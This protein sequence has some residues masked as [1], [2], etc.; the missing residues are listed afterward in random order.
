[1]RRSAWPLLVLAGL[2][3]TLS[4]ALASAAR[5]DAALQPDSMGYL[6]AARALHERG[7]YDSDHR[8]PGYPLLIALVQGATGVFPAALIALQMGFLLAA[9]ALAGAVARELGS[10]PTAVAFLTVLSPYALFLS[11]V[12]LPDTLF[13]LLFLA[14]VLLMLRARVPSSPGLA[15]ASGLCWGLLS[16]VRANGLFVGLVSAAV[17]LGLGCPAAGGRRRLAARVVVPMLAAGAAPL[18]AFATYNTAL[19]GQ[20][21]L[22]APAYRAYTV[23]EN[24]VQLEALATGVPVEAAK[25]RILEAARSRAGLPPAR[26]ATF[27]RAEKDAIVEQQAL[28]IATDYPPATLARVVLTAVVRFHTGTGNT[29]ITGYYLGTPREADARVRDEPSRIGRWIG[30]GASSA[31]HPVLALLIAGFAVTTRALAVAGAWVALRQRRWTLLL[32]CSAYLAC[33]TASAGFLAMTRYR[34]PVE[35]FVFALAAVALERG[36]GARGG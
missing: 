16:L 6:A 23:R 29:S 10:P 18:L 3:L 12:I 28:A 19:T 9:G 36:R 25:Q 34:Q 15:M 33:F 11:Q 22:V 2:Q 20:A 30:Q 24:L 4:L 32:M 31:G 7:V 1:M 8:L 14:H 21:R 13:L 17:L 5:P 35:P 26:W 27:T